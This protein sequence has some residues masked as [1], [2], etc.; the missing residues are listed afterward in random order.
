M[1][2][3]PVTGAGAGE[4]TANAIHWHIHHWPFQGYVSVNSESSATLFRSNVQTGRR[5][6]FDHATGM[7]FVLPGGTLHSSTPWRRDDSPRITVAFNVAPAP[8]AKP[9]DGK[10]VWVELFSADELARMRAAHE[11]WA[12]IVR[13]PPI[14]YTPCMYR[15]AGVCADGQASRESPS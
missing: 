14:P 11:R 13:R 6:Q 10:F 12:M 8:F 4:G 9:Q 2:P 5:W 7:Q 15:G 3:C 1:P